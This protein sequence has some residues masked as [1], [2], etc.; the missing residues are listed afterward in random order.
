M[1][2]QTT[3]LTVL[4][5]LSLATAE[6]HK[7]RRN[8]RRG[9]AGFKTKSKSRNAQSVF[10]PAPEEAGKSSPPRPEQKNVVVLL[11]DDVSTE[12]FPETGN[13]AL[14]GKL[15]GLTELKEDGAVFYPHFYS[16]SSIC[17]PAQSGLF[18][19]ME[20]GNLGGQQ[21]FAS[22]EYPGKRSYKTVP[23]PEVQFIPEYLRAMGYYTTGGGKLDYQVADVIPT[24]YTKILGGTYTNINGYMEQAWTPAIEM[25]VPFLTVLNMMDNHENLSTMKRENPIE[26]SDSLTQEAPDDLPNGKFGYATDKNL[27]FRLKLGEDP[28]FTP[29]A[30][31]DSFWDFNVDI[32]GYNG[33]F[34]ESTLNYADDSLPDY[35]PEEIGIQSLWARE[36]DLLRN[37]DWRIGQ[38]IKRLKEEDVYDDTVILIFGDHGSAHYKGKTMIQI[39][40]TKTPL[41]VKLPKDVPVSPNV[42]TGEDGYNEDNRLMP[43]KDAYPTLMSILGIEPEPWM[44]G[45][46]KAGM[47]EDVDFDYDALFSMVA[48]ESSLQGWKSFAAYNKEF[49]YQL[50]TLTLEVIEEREASG[51][52][53]AAVIE[54]AKHDALYANRYAAFKSPTF[55]RLKRLMYIN[56]END[57]Y[58]DQY[59]FLCA[60]D[61]R[62]PSE[63]LFDLR[64]DKWARTNL[65]RE[66]IYTPV[67][68]T[69]MQ[70]WGNFVEKVT[71]D[72]GPQDL[73]R[74]DDYQLENYNSL[75][76]ALLEWVDDLTYVTS[77]VD[78][79]DGLYGEE[80]KMAIQMWP[81]GTQ[82]P[83][84]DVDIDEETGEMS[85][86]TEGSVFRYSVNSLE[87][88]TKCEALGPTAK[89]E[90]EVM[91][92][93]D[94]G[95]E[96]TDYVSLRN[97]RSYKGYIYDDPS[98][99]GL[100]TVYFLGALTD[101]SIFVSEDGTFMEGNSPDFDAFAFDTR[102]G[103]WNDETQTW[104][105]VDPDTGE[106]TIDPVT[107]Y[108]EE[109]MEWNFESL[110]PYIFGPKRTQVYTGLNP[111]GS[112]FVS[113]RPQDTPM[114]RAGN[115]PPKY[116][117]TDEDVNKTPAVKPSVS[118]EFL[119]WQLI[120]GEF[121]GVDDPP[122]LNTNTKGSFGWTIETRFTSITNKSNFE[123]VFSSFNYE[124]L[125][126]NVGTTVPL[127]FSIG[128]PDIY[129][130][131]Q[132]IRKGYS[133]GEFKEIV[134]SPA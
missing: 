12:R 104:D 83:T 87:D 70:T 62:P 68:G 54:D 132:A 41:W 2:I 101:C 89:E 94:S 44:E 110:G 67:Y 85:C 28:E 40:S 74:L 11:I 35:V 25:G 46:A 77:G 76:S 14:K 38:V 79:E 26:L 116:W 102:D 113:S 100:S 91:T 124:C 52:S 86:E 24:F 39:Q 117:A 10:F 134:L 97:G 19:A 108:D 123:F 103:Q 51:L 27:N 18:A 92:P 21:Q 73:T 72:Y 66:Y 48:R 96:L 98:G 29:V 15:P 88:R 42:V 99:R 30:K 60:D 6:V 128:D 82:P 119:G 114:N 47:Y 34:D 59:R 1:K 61:A 17:A 20:P 109:T 115:P 45:V 84:A 50:H 78:W 118:F 71:L 32:T 55:A 106:W 4:S 58:P 69:T 9:D 81:D 23:P 133:D 43:M 7:P 3:A 8:L 121:T 64:T 13:A 129:V 53:S 126:W 16:S 107:V 36:Y 33:D 63:V 37:V 125:F 49:Y 57:S 80:N 56:A 120:R 5:V 112:P 111:D 95:I 130:F 122:E 105:G 22:N 65:L 90:I 127:D 75:R 93:Y 131:G 31:L